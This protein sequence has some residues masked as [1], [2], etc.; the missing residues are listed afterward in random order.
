VLLSGP[1][2]MCLIEAR[3]AD[4]RIVAMGCDMRYNPYHSFGSL[5]QW[6]EP[7]PVKCVVG[8]SNPSRAYEEKIK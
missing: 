2:A 3:A 8:G 1:I 4:D 7:A 6:L 5:A